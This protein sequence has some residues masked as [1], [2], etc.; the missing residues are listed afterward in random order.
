MLLEETDDEHGLTM[1]EILERLAEKGIG[2]ERKS[3]YDDISLLRDFGLDIVTRNPPR[4]EYAIGTRDF[5]FPELL[6]LV[7]AVQSSRFLTEK[8]CQHLVSRIKRLASKHQ[9]KQLSKQMHVEGRIRMQNESIYYNVDAIQTAIRDRRR[10]R[11]KYFEYNLEK[12]RSFRHE[13]NWYIENPGWLI[14]TDEYYYFISYNDTHQD[15]VRYRLDRMVNIEVL[16]E[17][18]TK[19]DA[20][21]AFNPGE[22]SARSFGMFGGEKIAVDLIVDKSIVGAIIDRF[23]KEVLL[24]P[25]DENRARVHVIVLKSSVFFGW[26]AQFGSLL[27]I[28][29]PREL[30]LEYKKHLATICENYE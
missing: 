16:D 13:G 8:K 7:D 25:I 4:T 6:L 23:G 9:A 22:F 17:P 5:E 29:A 27:T 18:T 2:A 28:E 24:T 15:F 19:N 14:Y 10:V 3:I 21:S 11:F 1:P 26:L 20:I 30:A 12:K